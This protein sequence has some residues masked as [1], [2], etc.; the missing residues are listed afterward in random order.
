M[1]QLIALA[2]IALVICVGL[3]IVIRWLRKGATA[4]VENKVLDKTTKAQRGQ[5]EEA[6]KAPKTLNDLAQDLRNGGEL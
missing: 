1:G 6:A 4:E 5:L 2:G 3:F